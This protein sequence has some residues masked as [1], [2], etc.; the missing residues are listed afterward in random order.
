M[1]E[2]M[3]NNEVNYENVRSIPIHLFDGS[4]VEKKKIEIE[5]KHLYSTIIKKEKKEI[6]REM[7]DD[8]D[9]TVIA[10]TKN[11]K[12]S[13]IKKIP[14]KINIVTSSVSNPRF[15]GT[16]APTQNGSLSSSVPSLA[17]VT[18]KSEAAKNSSPSRQNA[19]NEIQN[20]L[21]DAHKKLSTHLRQIGSS[22]S[23]TSRNRQRYLG[24]R[25]QSVE[26]SKR[27][28]IKRGVQTEDGKEESSQDLDKY[29]EVW[30]NISSDLDEIIKNANK[31]NRNTDLTRNSEFYRAKSVPINLGRK[32]LK[33][34]QNNESSE[35]EEVK[36]LIPET[37]NRNLF[38]LTQQ[39]KRKDISTTANEMD[40]EPIFFKGGNDMSKIQ[41]NVVNEEK[42]DKSTPEA[43]KQDFLS[44]F[45]EKSMLKMFLQIDLTL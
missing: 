36:K 38:H 6:S 19:L 8:V 32:P 4:I 9:E 27:N 18:R 24:T 43:T 26:C 28:E 45:P 41:E 14:V 42:I 30:K 17:E 25:S 33:S 22:T 23:P 31:D 10:K 11:N 15:Q 5:T 37:S 29:M 34:P 16:P 7:V 12:E 35:D 13:G 2:K 21:E 1:A 40:S 20:D 44:H 3:E 39:E